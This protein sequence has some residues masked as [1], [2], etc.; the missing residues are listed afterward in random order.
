MA[1]GRNA[2]AM[3]PESRPG[4]V[5]SLRE[6]PPHIQDLV[7]ELASPGPVIRT[8]ARKAL[9]AQGKLAVP[10]LIQLL[11]HPKPHI[12][13]EAAKA[14]A[15][16]ADPLAASAMVNALED[17]DDDVRWLAAEGL[18]ALGRDALQPLLSALI[19]RSKSDSLCKG[20]H[21]VCCALQ[22][23]RGLGPILRPLLAALEQPEP[24]AGSPLAAYTAL[25]K[26]RE[27]PPD[28]ATS[29]VFKNRKP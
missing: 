1:E 21:H 20:A 25:S 27:M 12:R 7:V 13:W 17:R 26:L 8:R 2:S 23:K 5:T 22:K 29:C 18:A 28:K 3:T 6:L 24:E 10:A 14:L 16:I 19:E 11:S 4:P 9:V 15:N